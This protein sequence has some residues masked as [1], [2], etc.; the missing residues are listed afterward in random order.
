M[1]RYED[2][3]IVIREG[4][5]LIGTTLFS[6]PAESIEDIYLISTIGDRF[7]L[8]AKEYYNDIKLWY[9]I[10]AANPIVRKDTLMVE[11]GLQIRIPFPLSNV[12]NHIRETNR[13]R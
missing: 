4:K 13:I 10:A 11:P 12:L 5:Q 7:D 8:L 6:A 2:S 1:N 9:I 3:P